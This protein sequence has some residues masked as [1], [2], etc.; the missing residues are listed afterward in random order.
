MIIAASSSSTA[1]CSS[2]AINLN[3]ETTSQ[4]V[5]TA[6]PVNHPTNNLNNYTQSSYLATNSEL[7]TKQFYKC[8]N[9]TK[10]N[11]LLKASCFLFK[12]C[13]MRQY[14]RFW[15]ILCEHA[16]ATRQIVCLYVVSFASS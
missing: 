7:V 5:K 10:E 13:H 6:V 15:T 4:T 8:L 11:F 2:E 3:V 14:K 16:L 12:V 9:K 1:S